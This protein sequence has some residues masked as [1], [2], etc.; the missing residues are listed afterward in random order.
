MDRALLSAKDVMAAPVSSM[1]YLKRF[2]KERGWF[3][4]KGDS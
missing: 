1:N 4:K 3:L 2:H